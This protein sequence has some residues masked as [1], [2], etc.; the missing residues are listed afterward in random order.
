[1]FKKTVILIF[2]LM[3]LS[4]SMI[5]SDAE[6]NK[7]APDFKLNDSNGNLVKLADYKG[8]WVVLEWVNY[9]CPFV[10]KHYN[11][12]NMQTLQKEYE[13]KG[14]IWLSICSSAPKKQG[15]FDED[16]IQ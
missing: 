14:V 15:N 8:K 12:K 13:K 6:I 5:A 7:S 9:D 4:V 16:M 11:S 3:G 1:M 10:K 2:L